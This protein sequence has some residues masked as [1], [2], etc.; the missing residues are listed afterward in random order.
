MKIL[1]C[2]KQVPDME[3][4]FKIDASSKWYDQADL[5][6][7]INEYDEYAAE[8]AVRLKEKVAG[9]ELVVLSIGPERVKD[10][11][12]KVLAMGADRGVHILDNEEHLKD[13]YQKASIIANYAKNENFDIVFTG[14][15]SEDRGS[16]QVAPLLAGLL[17]YNFVSTVVGFE[18]NDDKITVER[19]L[20]GGLKAKVS[21]P[22]PAVVSCQLGLNTPRYPTLP[23]IMK[24]KR[25]KLD[26]VNVA[27][28]L[29]SDA[30]VETQKIFI[31]EKKAGGIVLEGEVDKIA[32][33]LIKI[34]K[35]KTQ[36]VK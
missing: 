15:Q 21:L 28:L 6:Y 12:R 20:E 36:V 31:P 35:E 25:K 27:D 34:L 19:E 32:D 26:T 16:A 13:P 29:E 14:L 10:V 17:G 8:E 3:S 23:N 4:K 1:V 2:V 9:S 5:V 7:K 30:L 18:Y 11:I 33:E 22:L 24:A